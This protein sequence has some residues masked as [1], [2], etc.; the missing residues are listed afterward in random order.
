MCPP[1]F[2]EQAN[3]TR[4]DSAA[5]A[6]K[7]TADRRNAS[8][9]R[10]NASAAAASAAAAARN[11]SSYHETDAAGGRD[12]TVDGMDAAFH[13]VVAAAGLQNGSMARLCRAA[14][15]Q[16]ALS[17]FRR[18][19]AWDLSCQIGPA[20]CAAAAATR[21]TAVQTGA[22]HVRSR[23][24]GV[25]SGESRCRSGEARRENGEARDGNGEACRRPEQFLRCT[26]YGVMGPRSR[27]VGWRR[28]HGRDHSF[29]KTV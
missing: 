10:K 4:G 19:L 18:W 6:P 15:R 7:A 20:T 21:E 13:G 9:G 12:V 29:R 3:A 26:W 14:E 5:R 27:E 11:A 28:T 2:D 17:R 22:A 24:A 16:T 25:W 8:A 23:E 1:A